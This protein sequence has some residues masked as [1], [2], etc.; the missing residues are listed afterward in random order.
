MTIERHLGGLMVKWDA[1]AGETAKLQKTTSLTAP[2][3]W[4]NVDVVPVLEGNMYT[5]HIEA[6]PGTPEFYRIMIP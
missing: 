5:L 6:L 3:S 2:I 1:V 4:T